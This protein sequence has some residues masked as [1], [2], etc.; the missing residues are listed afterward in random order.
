MTGSYCSHCT[1]TRTP[2]TGSLLPT[3]LSCAIPLGERVCCGSGPEGVDPSRPVSARRIRATLQRGRTERSEPRDGCL[4]VVVGDHPWCSRPDVAESVADGIVRRRRRWREQPTRP[5]CR[6]SRPDLSTEPTHNP[7]SPARAVYYRTA[8]AASASGAPA[9]RSPA[10]SPT[11]AAR[12]L[13]GPRYRRG[14]CDGSDLPVAQCE[15][16]EG[17]EP[18]FYA[19]TSATADLHAAYNYLVSVGE[20]FLGLKSVRIPCPEPLRKAPQRGALRPRR[21]DIVHRDSAA[22]LRLAGPS[23]SKQQRGSLESASCR[24]CPCRPLR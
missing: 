19:A 20:H 24:R 1:T 23:A 18:H 3:G 13:Q 10:T 15:D 12:L 4:M 16:G 11:P 7:S 9:P 17:R 5:W 2:G 14:S 6:S 22:Q 8:L 21:L